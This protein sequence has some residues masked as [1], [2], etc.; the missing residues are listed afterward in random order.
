[1]Y[2]ESTLFD[3]S[4]KRKGFNDVL[5]LLV[6]TGDDMCYTAVDE[7]LPWGYLLSVSI[8]TQNEVKILDNGVR[9]IN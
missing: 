6:G 7:A 1:M 8:P 5:T 4:Y 3:T 9:L 2:H